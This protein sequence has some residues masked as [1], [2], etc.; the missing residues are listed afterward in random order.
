LDFEVRAI[1]QVEKKKTQ[2]KVRQK[3]LFEEKENLFKYYILNLII[4]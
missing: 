4:F 2:K 3:D 1:G